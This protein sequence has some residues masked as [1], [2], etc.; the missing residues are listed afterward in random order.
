LSTK[1]CRCIKVVNNE[2]EI[3]GIGTGIVFDETSWLAHIIVSKYHQRKGIGTIIVQNRIEYLMET[4]NCKTITLTATD[5]GYPVYKRLGFNEESMYAIMVRPQEC[6]NNTDINSN[7]I[8]AMPK[9]YEEMI[10]LDRLT[11]GENRENLIKPILNS[12]Y[13]YVKN[14]HIEGFYLPNFGDSGVT[15]ITEEAGIALLGE[16]IKEDKRIYIPE[17][18]I[19]AYNFLIKKGYQEV[20]RI[21]RMIIGKSFE[22]KSHYCYSRIGGFAG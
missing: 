16:R 18:N 15:A 21:H 4:C 8:Q 19:K 2:D 11:S 10:K 22:H 17:E 6:K 3:L 12:G 7:I 13:V 20:K 9:H 1:C 14:N 5:Q